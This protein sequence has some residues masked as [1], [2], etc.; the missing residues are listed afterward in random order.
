MSDEDTQPQPPAKP[1]AKTST[2]PLK[3]ETVRITLRAKPGTGITQPKKSTGV[4]PE[5]K[6]ATAPIPEAKKATAPVPTLEDTVPV[7]VPPTPTTP[8]APAPPTAPA[9][10]KPPAAPTGAKTVPLKPGPAAPAAPGAPT[11]PL[12]QAPA[13]A[14]PG[15][16]AAPSAPGAP[17]M[18]LGQAPPAASP[19]APGAPTMPLG[20]A[21]PAAAGAKT[22][23]LAQTPGGQQ[24]GKVTSPM[25]PGQTTSLPS[26]T[27]KLGPS[28]APMSVPSKAL[29][30]D[31]QLIEE[32]SGAESG[33]LVLSIFT[34][35]L[36]L[37][38]MLL[39]MTSSDRVVRHPEG[40]DKKITV[41]VHG[42]PDWDS[43]IGNKHE[44]LND[45]AAEQKFI[46]QTMPKVPVH[47]A[48]PNPLNANPT[49]S[50]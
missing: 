21:P 1:S 49:P 44:Y 34:M 42:D 27:V 16:P 5:P 40:E 47:P 36:A 33:M 28:T 8:G 25:R 39:E 22:I 48:D 26:A 31:S 23:P 12:G 2:V 18:P 20:Q 15:A 6:K 29:G 24:P 41:P 14:A 30:E 35:I 17:T 19:S 43:R 10:P 3:K 9:A 38:I 13:P 45:K 46:N 32:E 50:A 4:V 37:G 11:M 7:K